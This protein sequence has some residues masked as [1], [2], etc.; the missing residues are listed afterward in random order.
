MRSYLEYSYQKPSAEL[1]QD[2]SYKKLLEQF[3]L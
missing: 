2:K 3:A 1:K